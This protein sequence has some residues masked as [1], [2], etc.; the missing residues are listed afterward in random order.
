MF[1]TRTCDLGGAGIGEEF[2]LTAPGLNLPPR[3]PPVWGGDVHV[4]HL[5]LHRSTLSRF[6]VVGKVC[7]PAGPPGVFGGRVRMVGN[8]PPLESDNVTELHRRLPQVPHR[9]RRERHRIPPRVL[10]DGEPRLDECACPVEIGP[11]R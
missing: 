7:R 9:H 6:Q 5:S 2:T 8:R 1:P 10:A 11:V 3:V 4:G